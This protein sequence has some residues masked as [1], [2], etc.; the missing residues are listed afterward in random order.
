MAIRVEVA[1]VVQPIRFWREGPVPLMLSGPYKGRA[2]CS[3]PT[4]VWH[5]SPDG[6]EWGYRGSGP[7]DCALN[8]LHA[9]L[10]PGCDGFPPVKLWKGECSQ[11]AW[12]LHQP[13]KVAW[14]AFLPEEGGELGAYVMDA[15]L[16][17]AVDTW[18]G[19]ESARAAEC[20]Q[21]GSDG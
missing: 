6:I 11:V 17:M 14:I 2:C 13:F 19:R 3:I 18:I 5:H 10:P 21:D 15:W 12:D 20:A 7:A 8:I 1:G 9:L 16:T 4:R